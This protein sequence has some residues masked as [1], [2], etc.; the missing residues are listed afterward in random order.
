M[1]NPLWSYDKTY[2]NKPEQIK[3]PEPL[4]L[5]NNFPF[6]SAFPAGIFVQL[7]HHGLI[8]SYVDNTF[9]MGLSPI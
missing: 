7:L 8:N 6:E 2:P 4:C 1:K 3:I 5:S 9:D